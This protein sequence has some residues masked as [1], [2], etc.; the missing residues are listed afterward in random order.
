MG[1]KISIEDRDLLHP[2]TSAVLIRR[3]VTPEL[4][5]FLKLSGVDLDE[6]WKD[7]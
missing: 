5:E 1:F 7:W 6:Q 3:A 4:L 2:E